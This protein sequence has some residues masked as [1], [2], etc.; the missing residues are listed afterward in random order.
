[1]L[2]DKCRMY[3]HEA[4]S[5][6]L[7]SLFFNKEWWKE[8]L[9]SPAPGFVGSGCG[10]PLKVVTGSLMGYAQKGSKIN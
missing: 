9:N 7:V 2:Q 10:L 8:N 6:T 3:V 1:N 4:T 5:L